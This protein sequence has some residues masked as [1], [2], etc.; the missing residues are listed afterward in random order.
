MPATLSTVDAILK[1][2]YKEYLDNLNEANF[3]LSQVETRKDTVQGR[4]ARHA[5]HLGRSSGVG[6][7]A[8]NGTLPTAA[9]Q[10]YATVPVPVRYVYGRIQLSGPTIKQA[11]T[12]RG[13]FIDALDAEMEGIKKDAMKDVNR[14]LWGTSNGVIAQCG[15]TSSSTTVVLASTTGS[16]A[17]RQLFFDG[18]M[19][20]DIGTVASPTTVASARTISSVDETN[21][22]I[23]ISGAAVTTSS[24]HYVFRSGAGGASSN[25]GQPG[26]GQIELT[27]LQTIVDDTAVLHTINPSSQ[28]KWKSYVNS[29]SGTNRSITETLITGSIMKTLTNSGKKP[30]L[31]VSAEGVNLAISNLLLSL[32]RNMEQTNLKGG[33]AGIQFYSPSVSGKG[34][35]APTALYADFDCPNN[36]LYGINPDVLVYHQVGDGFQFMDL[37]G[38]VM[39]RKPDVDAYEATLYAYGEL[40]CK[41]RNAHFVI[42]D[43]TEVTI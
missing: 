10:S 4:I 24:S 22:T 41:Q 18:G 39:N 21:K 2:D 33:Y 20:V 11:V 32:K 6:A 16:T 14:Q 19:I 37:D 38:A 40:A 1:D 29:N 34:D 26:D 5:V 31:L 36:R 42:K 25:T 12:D 7:R 13:A 35:E 3:I 17:L 15:T 8:E 9:N 23:A 28:P 43:I 30:S 27:G